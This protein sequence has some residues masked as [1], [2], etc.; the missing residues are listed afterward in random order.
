MKPQS[1]T[2]LQYILRHGSVTQGDAIKF[3]CFRLAS[4]ISD[5]KADGVPIRSSRE[6]VIKADGS[7]TYIARYSM[8]KEAAKTWETLIE[9][10]T[11]KA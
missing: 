6:E 9:S 4:R 2:V 8:P 5:L 11:Q 1:K 10:G 3:G 7:R